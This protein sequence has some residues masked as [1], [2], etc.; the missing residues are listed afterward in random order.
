M[1]ES[2][3]Y[4]DALD[5]AGQNPFIKNLASKIMAARKGSPYEVTR[6]IATEEAL[7][8]VSAALQTGDVSHL[9]DRYG[10]NFPESIRTAAKTAMQRF[11]EVVKRIFN[12]LTGR[13]LTDQQVGELLGRTMKSGLERGESSGEAT[14]GPAAMRYSVIDD[15]KDRISEEAKAV[16]ASDS[17]LSLLNRTL[18]TKL[19]IALRIPAYKAVHDKVRAFLNHTNVE[20]FEAVNKAPELLARNEDASD[21]KRELKR[22]DPRVVLRQEQ[23]IAKA[24]KVIYENTLRADAENKKVFTDAELRAKGLNDDQ[25]RVYRTFM[26]AVNV[27][28]DN[29]AKANITRLMMQA[30]VIDGDAAVR[31]HNKELPLNEHLANLREQAGQMAERLQDN[32]NS[33]DDSA[34]TARELDVVKAAIDS[35][36]DIA[37]KA[38]RLK[39]EGYAPAMRFGEHTVTAYD[40]SGR[41]AYFE[42]F[43]SKTAAIR[44]EKAFKEENPKWRVVRGTMSQEKFK[45]FQGLTPET[46][47]LFAKEAGYENDPAYQEYLKLAINNSSPL[48]RMIHRKGIAG[49]SQDLPRVLSSFVMSNARGS[50]RAI[51]SSQMQDALSA[52]KQAHPHDGKLYDDAAKLVDYVVNPKEEAQFL[53]NMLFHF[54]L[55][56]SFGF[57]LVN[58]LQP[59]HMTSAQIALYNGGKA[60]EAV[61]TVA[62]SYKRAVQAMRTGKPPQ[63]YAEAFK[64]AQ[65]EGYLDPA[66]TYALQGIERGRSGYAHTW[67]GAASHALS[68][69]ARITETINRTSTFIAAMDFAKAT[70]EANLRKAGFKDAYD[71]ATRAI[72]VTQGVYDKSNRP[73]AARGAVG[74]LLMAYKMYPINFIE[75]GARMAKEGLKGNP[76]GYTG[77]AMLLG[78]LAVT[79]GVTGLPLAQDLIDALEGIF[80]GFGHPFNADRFMREHMKPEAADVLMHGVGAVPGAPF[81]IASRMSMGRQVPGLPQLINP[82]LSDDESRR[83]GQQLG[84]AAEN[85]LLNFY[86]AYKLAFGQGKYEEAVIQASPKWAKSV[87]KA[88]EM[89]TKGEYTDSKGRKVRDVTA[90]DAI[91]KALDIQPAS[92]TRQQRIRGIEMQDLSIQKNKEKYF[93]D[94]MFDAAMDNDSTAMLQAQADLEKWNRDNPLYQVNID[95]QRQVGRRVIEARK[96]PAQRLKT[97]KEMRWIQGEAMDASQ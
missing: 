79:S 97:P 4:L 19:N 95:Y 46:V 42:G 90:L 35:S 80:A 32:I 59:L 67:L 40:E 87:A 8:E 5:R 12:R 15:V 83:A 16:L 55:A 57:G 89:A 9:K 52:L 65:R 34:K 7:A 38:D 58:L 17:Q 10:L 47:A 74:S 72:D 64:R 44:A 70:G 92:I 2:R 25:I 39:S 82:T 20:A 30:G 24:A 27:S 26:D 28:L 18:G 36:N 61:K 66:N 71:F 84:G 77:L 76:A 21:Y 73:N 78:V 48:K 91:V 43:D 75:F 41:V 11:F 93:A 3:E 13:G 51:F 31:L 33:G 53:K 56:G 86:D 45:Q 69:I 63:E 85:L 14:S 96:G 60:A 54:Y 23:D 1:A 88:F 49:Y 81:D 62:G 37:D 29:F 50:S 68:S 6:S 22:L 94:R